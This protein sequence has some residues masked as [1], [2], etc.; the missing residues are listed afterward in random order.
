MVEGRQIQQISGCWTL[1]LYICKKMA[2]QKKNRQVY[3][4]KFRFMFE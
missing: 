1:E 2:K 4:L 3:V